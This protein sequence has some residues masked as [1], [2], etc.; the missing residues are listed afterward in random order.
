MSESIQLSAG[1]A[2]NMMRRRVRTIGAGAAAAWGASAALSALIVFAWL[3][4]VV[5]SPGAFR[6]AFDLIALGAFIVIAVR[7][8]RR[9]FRDA[10]PLAVARRLDEVAGTKGRIL[11][12]V[13]LAGS[14]ANL[15]PLTAG[16]AQMAV[17][18]AVAMIGVVRPQVAVPGN[19][20]T[21]PLALFVMLIAAIGV[22][23]IVSPRLVATQI[24]RFADPLGDHPPY[25]ALTF[26]VDPGNASVIY[27]GAI[28]VRATV[29]GGNAEQLQLVLAGNQSLPMFPEGDNVWRATVT[30][31]TSPQTYIVREGRARSVQ[32][33]LDV[34]TVP[35]LED[36]KFKVQ[37]PAYTNRPPY[38]GPLPQN[39][40][41]GLP[42]TWVE[43]TARSN[44][45]LSAGNIA[46]A[47]TKTS[48]DIAMQP[49]APNS[50]EVVGR[51]QI[52]LS[53]KIT[54]GVRD[55]AGQKSTETL[56]TAVTMLSDQRPIIRMIEPKAT[57][58][59]TPDA[60]I[61][62]Q[63]LAE[64][65]YGISSVSI[66]RGL[67]DSRPR[68]TAIPVP[69]PAPTMFPAMMDLNLSDYA[70]VPGD[71]IQLFG[72]AEDNDPAG[73]KGSESTVV[74]IQIVSQKDM[75]RMTIA[76]EGME[77]LQSKYASAMRRV[78]QLDAKLQTL[79]KDLSKLDPNSPL[80]DA[81]KKQIQDLSDQMNKD[82][83]AIQKLA[84]H[85]LPFDIDHALTQQLKD[86][87]QLLKETSIE[88]K[89]SAAKPGLSVAGALD[90]VKDLHDRLSIKHD[91]LQQNAQQPLDHLAKIFPLIQDQARFLDLYARQKD[92]AD[93]LSSLEGQKGQDDPQLKTRMRDLQDEQQQVR[94][95]LKQ[96]LDDIDN[97]IAQLPDDKRVDDL[98]TT[99]RKFDDDV[100]ASAASGQMQ[101]AESALE[102]FSGSAASNSSHAAAD[103]LS[104][105]IGRCQSMG[106]QGEACLK[107]QPK[108][109]AGLGNTVE[110]MLDAT[111]L[112]GMGQS[113]SGGYS[114]MRNSLQNVGL[115]GTLPVHGQE[116][117]GQGGDA[118]HGVATNAD[119]SPGTANPDQMNSV[120]KQQASGGSDAPVPSQ[121][122]Q[123]VGDYFRRVADEMSN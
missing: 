40:L 97:H 117:S 70:V 7:I 45:P 72:R 28:D 121:Y 51:F 1:N 4:I 88:A 74:T 32:Y 93:R 103:T 102:G 83:A 86:V 60:L 116:S 30:D 89:D 13:D 69:A 75:D 38:I 19:S 92:L 113:G 26:D 79:Q 81:V 112:G 85:D 110:Q 53:G 52:N 119:G 41:A 105:F 71:V 10:S 50:S 42:G 66:F 65:D 96:L 35:K 101:D 21:R 43:V 31:V 24:A 94:N 16:L 18:D 118:D 36:V 108:L 104:K 15:P 120:K 29:R 68:P 47:Q 80:A 55:I 5:D 12:G 58:F 63:A 37:L 76:R 14:S 48:S 33:N 54:I 44:R 59:A 25:S 87:A 2:L 17:R 64:D 109:A 82:S 22:L 78:E 106:D 73:A 3:D 111:G 46:F 77:A 100:R 90:T 39:G 114:A 57:S 67:N 6:L 107:F 56:T 20:F 49:T 9:A 115:Y 91:D 98:R 8:I 34:I 27:G 62:V 123:R 84:D 95:D 122:K 61:K 99:A 11:A 23:S